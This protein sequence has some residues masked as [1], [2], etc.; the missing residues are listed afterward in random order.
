[1]EPTVPKLYNPRADQLRAIGFLA[2]V[3]VHFFFPLHEQALRTTPV[4]KLFAPLIENAQSG[5]TLFFFV[6]GYILARLIQAQSDTRFSVRLL[7]GELRAGAS[8][9]GPDA[10]TQWPR[11]A[12]LLA[13]GRKMDARQARQEVEL[14][15]WI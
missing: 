8:Q 14:I 3:L 6:S 5:V 11:L 12:C 15:T 4:V 2:V 1:V 10:S 13:G 9:L 7:G